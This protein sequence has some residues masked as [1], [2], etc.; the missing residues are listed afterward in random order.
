V[1][2]ARAVHALERNLL[3]GMSWDDPAEQAAEPAGPPPALVPLV[4]RC[5]CGQVISERRWVCR[6]HVDLIGG[7]QNNHR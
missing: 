6:A 3:P 1:R 2:A 7:E 4:H 5:Q